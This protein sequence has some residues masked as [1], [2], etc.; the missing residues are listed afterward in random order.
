MDSTRY[1]RYRLE[2]CLPADENPSLSVR[3]FPCF[4][5][6][7]NGATE[8]LWGAT[9]RITVLFLEY[10]FGF[11][12]PDADTLPVVKGRLDRTYLSGPQPGDTVNQD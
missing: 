5:F 12:L 8:I 10:I 4:Q 1:G 2:T 11:T 9:F 7:D 3:D 6:R